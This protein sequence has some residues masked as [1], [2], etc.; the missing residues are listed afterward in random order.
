M[1]NQVTI[2][3]E[4]YHQLIDT[5]T[6]VSIVSN[7]ETRERYLSTDTILHILGLSTKEEVE[8]FAKTTQNATAAN[9][10]RQICV[11]QSSLD[12]LTGN[13]EAVREAAESAAEVT[14]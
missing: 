6:R 12:N 14:A 13:G 11:L 1:D 7:L 10:R 2:S 8:E 5:Q 9:L 4:E 3:T